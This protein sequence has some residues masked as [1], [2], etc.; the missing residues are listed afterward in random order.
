MVQ[1]LEYNW[2]GRHKYRKLKSMEDEY[3]PHYQTLYEKP[4]ISDKVVSSEDRAL[5]AEGL[6]LQQK[7]CFLNY[8]LYNEKSW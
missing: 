7:R 6:R 2:G 1:D 8:T 5:Y 3:M 4:Q